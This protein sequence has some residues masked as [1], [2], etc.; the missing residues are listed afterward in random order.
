[1]LEL[2]EAFGDDELAESP[3]AVYSIL[4]MWSLL[5]VFGLDVPGA[6]DN[7]NRIQDSKVDGKLTTRMFLTSESE[8]FNQF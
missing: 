8:R 5:L 3:N 7:G 4:A 2:L 1:M 6:P